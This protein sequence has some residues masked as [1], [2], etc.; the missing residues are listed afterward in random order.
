MGDEGSI[1]GMGCEEEESGEKG[2]VAE[3]DGEEDALQPGA[4]HEPCLDI[5]VWEEDVG[6]L[7]GEQVYCGR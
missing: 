3:E 1:D 6:S 2:N 5:G 4:Q 7:Q